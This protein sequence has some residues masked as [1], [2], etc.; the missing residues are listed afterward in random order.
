[1]VSQRF[2]RLVT[3]HG[4]THM[5]LIPTERYVW[6]PLRRFTQPTGA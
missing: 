2:A 1:M 5:D 4:L 3:E 6:D